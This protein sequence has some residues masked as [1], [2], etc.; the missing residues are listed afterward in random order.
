MNGYL[1]KK[2]ANILMWIIFIVLLIT[3]YIF[4]ISGIYNI[5]YLIVIIFSSIL[6]MSYDNNEKSDVDSLALISSMNIILSSFCLIYN[7]LDVSIV[8]FILIIIST[9]Y[10]LILNYI[11]VKRRQNNKNNIINIFRDAMISVFILTFLLCF[12]VKYITIMFGMSFIYSATII[13]AQAKNKSER[14]TSY[15]ASIPGSFVM[16]FPLIEKGEVLKILL[17]IILMIVIGIICNVVPY[18]LSN[19]KN[20]RKKNELKRISIVIPVL[21]FILSVIYFI[22]AN[23]YI[24][25]SFYVGCLFFIIPMSFTVYYSLY[26]EYE[27]KTLS[28][29]FFA[30]FCSLAGTIGLYLIVKYYPYVFN[31]ARESETF[32]MNDSLRLNENV[33]NLI[34][35]GLAI[36]LPIQ[37]IIINRNKDKKINEINDVKNLK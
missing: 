37:M 30:L 36:Y 20:D 12:F 24:N 16:F 8:S 6:M 10:P 31:A 35:I 9:V 18:N 29:F 13:S 17:S 34:I 4:H 21:L 26:K 22:F 14:D 7:I 5:I 32:T 1:N 3:Y 15:M 11:K 23:E 25:Y 19:F 28:T 2:I 27:R 33:D